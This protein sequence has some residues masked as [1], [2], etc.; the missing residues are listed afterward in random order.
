MHQQ[1][2]RELKG[3]F[4]VYLCISDMIFQYLY[5]R[6][7]GGYKWGSFEFCHFS[8]VFHLYPIS[9]VIVWE[10][11]PCLQYC[12]KQRD[13]NLKVYLAVCVHKSSENNTC[14]RHQTER[15]E[16]EGLVNSSLFLKLS[17]SLISKHLMEFSKNTDSLSYSVDYLTIIVIIIFFSL[18]LYIYMYRYILYWKF[19]IKY[20]MHYKDDSCF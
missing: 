3:C 19:Q 4:Q 14:E 10:R 20:Y 7:E 11:L 16:D 18:S 15:V 8:F 12:T 1:V 9:I 2:Y 6:H 17:A 13:Q 5:F